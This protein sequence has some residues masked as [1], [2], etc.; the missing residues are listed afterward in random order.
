MRPP[1][2]I[3]ATFSFTARAVA[4]ISQ[5][6]RDLESRDHQ[7]IGAVG[8]AWGHVQLADGS[9]HER[10]VIGFYNTS[11]MDEV[12]RAS[13]QNVGGVDLIV[14]STPDQAKNFDGR[15]VDFSPEQGFF[16]AGA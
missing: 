13:V 11:D 7:P 10:P 12:A 5:M 2:F 9:K 14:F 1:G 15:N 8:F 16:I 6:R 3:P 4:M